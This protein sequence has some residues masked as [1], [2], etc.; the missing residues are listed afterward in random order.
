M[1]SVLFRL[2]MGFFVEVITLSLDNREAPLPL[3]YS[4]S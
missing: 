1:K 3:L 2:L 4:S